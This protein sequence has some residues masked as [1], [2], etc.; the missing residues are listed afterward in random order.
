MVPCTPLGIMALLKKYNIE[1]KGKNAVVV[2]RSRI[3]GKPL[4]FLL[5]RENATV[6]ICHSKT[7]NLAEIT[8]RADI[9]IAAMGKKAF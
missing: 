8:S 9:L 4:S 6:T 3:V 5:L 1:L 7:Q 2:G